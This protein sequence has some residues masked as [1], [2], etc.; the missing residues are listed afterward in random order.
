MV[1]V[2]VKK[3]NSNIKEILFKGHALYSDYGKD[4]VCAA[5]S[6]IVITTINGILSID[7]GAV[8][9]IE[10]PNLVIKINN[11]SFV[12]DKLIENMLNLLKELEHDYPKNI[13]IL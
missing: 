3:E 13:E 10:K 12:C 4:I 8:S 6:S 5:I 11:N 7:K 1:K 9:Y 2:F